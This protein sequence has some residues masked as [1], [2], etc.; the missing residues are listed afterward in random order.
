MR[1]I[2]IFTAGE[3]ASTNGIVLSA[4]PTSAPKKDNKN[5]NYKT[6][7]SITRSSIR[8]VRSFGNGA[9][10]ARLLF[11]SGILINYALIQSS[12]NVLADLNVISEMS[13]AECAI[14]LISLDPFASIGVGEPGTNLLVNSFNIVRNVSVSSRLDSTL[15]LLDVRS[16]GV[17]N[18]SVESSKNLMSDVVISSSAE[19]VFAFFFDSPAMLAPSKNVDNSSPY[20]F[21]KNNNNSVV[22]S[23][24]FGFSN[25]NVRGF[26][27]QEMNNFDVIEIQANLMENV[28]VFSDN[29]FATIFGIGV[30]DV[31]APTSSPSILNINNNILKNI[32]ASGRKDA[33]GGIASIESKTKVQQIILENNTLFGVSGSSGNSY[34]LFVFRSTSIDA[35]TSSNYSTSLTSHSNIF[36]DVSARGVSS[37]VSVVSAPTINGVVEINNSNNMMSFISL[38]DQGTII[39]AIIST[40]CSLSLSFL[41]TNNNYNNN[42]VLNGNVFSN[43]FLSSTADANVG[44]LFVMSQIANLHQI[45]IQRNKIENGE[46]RSSTGEAALGIFNVRFSITGSSS[47]CDSCFIKIKNCS[48]SN[49]TATSQM[50]QAVVVI[51]L[52]KGATSGY[53]KI[54]VE[55][56]EIS[57]SIVSSQNSPASLVFFWP[58]SLSGCSSLLIQNN[59]IEE[60]FVQ[61]AQKNADLMLVSSQNNGILDENDIQIKNNNIQKI[62]LSSPTNNN[63]AMLNGTFNQNNNNIYLKNNSIKLSSSSSS[64]NSMNSNGLSVSMFSFSSCSFQQMT[65]NNSSLQILDQKWL[66]ICDSSKCSI[67]RVNNIIENTNNLISKILINDSSISSSLNSNQKE[68]SFVSFAD[69]Q[70]QSSSKSSLNI[71]LENNYLDSTSQNQI[72]EYNSVPSFV[73]VEIGCNRWLR[74]VSR[75]LQLRQNQDSNHFVNFTCLDQTKTKTRTKNSNSDRTN[76]TILPPPTQQP[77][78]SLIKS[79]SIVGL[80]ATTTFGL[81]A[82]S[83]AAPVAVRS[84]AVLLGVDQIVQ[85]DCESLFSEEMLEEVPDVVSSPMQLYISSYPMGLIV[86]DF[87]FILSVSAFW[88][89]GSYVCSNISLPALKDRFFSSSKRR[90]RTEEKKSIPLLFSKHFI[91]KSKVM[92]PLFNFSMMF[93]DPMFNSSITLL[94]IKSVGIGWKILGALI[95][96]V[97]VLCG[98]FV[99]IIFYKLLYSRTVIE[100]FRKF[101]RYEQKRTENHLVAI[102][103]LLMEPEGEWRSLRIGMRMDE[104][105]KTK[106]TKNNNNAKN[107]KNSKSNN[108][109]SIVKKEDAFLWRIC[110]PIIDGYTARFPRFV[111]VDILTILGLSLAMII[112]NATGNCL[113]LGVLM[114]VPLFIHFML[115]IFYRP[116]QELLA[117]ILNLIADLL[118]IILVICGLAKVDGSGIEVVALILL[119]LQMML[120]VLTLISLALTLVEFVRGNLSQPKEVERS[121][122][123]FDSLSQVMKKRNEQDSANR[124]RNNEKETRN[125]NEQRGRRNLEYSPSNRPSA[126]ASSNDR[127]RQRREETTPNRNGK[128]QQIE[129]RNDSN[130]NHKSSSQFE[131]RN[132]ER[133]E[134]ETPT[135]NRNQNEQRRNYNNN[136][137]DDHEE[138]PRRRHRES[139]RRNQNYNRSE[140]KRRSD[141]SGQRN[142]RGH[143]HMSGRFREMDW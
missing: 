32:S 27:V 98:F 120:F 138:F 128:N 71:Q 129:R 135:R 69:Y 70:Q 111:V 119:I 56:S 62:S 37:I 104:N 39:S 114:L 105:N 117:R 31:V 115:L 59:K 132:R 17:G 5:N 60:I 134:E 103:Y 44:V 107:N 91:S 4:P 16:A 22:N 84:H 73:S 57:N 125:Q 136:D 48:I 18:Y 67:L 95:S 20:F 141:D 126:V 38:T 83:S 3:V 30:D 10:Y 72:L 88:F 127:N 43:I 82:F 80:S 41:N 96:I 65:I 100:K 101:R 11:A 93:V 24:F 89:V 19:R 94:A 78:D 49:A 68:L 131:Q 36:H 33:G 61:S 6:I 8:D 90:N 47:S 143:T 92:I 53:S 9:F 13:S 2:S 130:N 112:G 113:V 66:D 25:A 139:D 118:Q 50:K 42:L 140:E 29:G 102:W 55:N 77:K 116:D 99:F 76:T 1:N 106:D 86:G 35:S 137:D 23:K 122:K 26:R 79:P 54:S 40:F 12:E 81:A 14:S 51:F 108:N 34:A 133:R 85:D 45:D 109:N 124:K 64:S 28:S 97:I 46:I 87:I 7:F 74:S 58:A 142:G 21:V 75:S 52:S 110:E 121:R 15:Q 123:N 63:V